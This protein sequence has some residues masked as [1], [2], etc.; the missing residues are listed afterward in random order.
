MGAIRPQTHRHRSRLL[1][2]LNLASTS[3]SCSNPKILA[4]AVLLRSDLTTLEEHPYRGVLL[5]LLSFERTDG[6]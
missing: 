1:L 5:Q 2:S 6:G 3:V 4:L